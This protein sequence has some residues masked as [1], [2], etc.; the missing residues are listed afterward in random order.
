MCVCSGALGPLR[1]ILCVCGEIIISFPVNY[2]R[3]GRLWVFSR[4]VGLTALE[5][6]AKRESRNDGGFENR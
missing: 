5:I 2:T 3:Y 1:S 6:S 4:V